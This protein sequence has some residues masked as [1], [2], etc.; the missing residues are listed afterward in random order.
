MSFTLKDQLLRFDQWIKTELDLIHS[1]VSYYIAAQA[2]LIL[3]FI[4][5]DKLKSARQWLISTLPV[6]GILASIIAFFSI[7][8]AYMA[9]NDLKIKRQTIEDQCIRK[10]MN[11]DANVVFTSPSERTGTQLAF[12]KFGPFIVPFVMTFFWIVVLIYYDKTQ[13]SLWH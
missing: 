5:L 8:A 2:I 7:Y 11:G 9:I 3:I 13:A 10:A 1:R 12:G 6:C 4:N